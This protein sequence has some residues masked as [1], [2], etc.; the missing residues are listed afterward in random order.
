MAVSHHAAIG[1]GDLACKL[2]RLPNCALDRVLA[3][4]GR[5]FRIASEFLGYVLR[6]EE[7][8]ELQQNARDRVGWC[9]TL[10]LRI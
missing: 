8:L 4:I 2:F 10:E 7:G 9:P 6:K 1:Q 5:R 3:A